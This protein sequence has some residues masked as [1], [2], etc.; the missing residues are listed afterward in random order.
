MNINYDLISVRR[1]K[2]KAASVGSKTLPFCIA[3]DPRLT[4]FVTKY[5]I[6]LELPSRW[7]NSRLTGRSFITISRLTWIAVLTWAAR[8]HLDT[9]RSL[10][11]GSMRL[12]Y[13]SL[14]P[15]HMPPG[16]RSSI[17]AQAAGR[18]ADCR[19]RKMAKA[20]ELS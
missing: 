17:G 16:L 15:G 18:T 19:V 4:G 10:R 6:W 13:A 12:S 11:K 7:P 5:K 2:A 3:Y 9:S 1:G 8:S 14:L 20:H